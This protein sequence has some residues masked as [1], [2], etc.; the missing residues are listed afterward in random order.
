MDNCSDAQPWLRTLAEYK[1]NS[2]ACIGNA[3]QRIFHAA[4]IK[5]QCMN[6]SPLFT[7]LCT[8]PIDIWGSLQYGWATTHFI[9]LLPTT[10]SFPQPQMKW[11]IHSSATH[12]FLFPI[13]NFVHAYILTINSNT[14]WILKKNATHQLELI[15]TTK[16][17]K[18]ASLIK[19]NWGNP[20]LLWIFT[21]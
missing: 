6:G 4:K 1:K 3:P 21:Q 9:V 8:N 5:N 19:T 14:L 7:E 18:Q 20:S 12:I 13:F 2:D 17:S 16:Y 10:P 15:S 11:A